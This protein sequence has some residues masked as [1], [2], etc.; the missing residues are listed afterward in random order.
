MMQMVQFQES[1]LFG[2]AN[3][4]PRP[5]TTA[6]T[7]TIAYCKTARTFGQRCINNQVIS[8]SVWPELQRTR[9]SAYGR[10]V[11]RRPSNMSP[12]K[13]VT[14]LASICKLKAG[15]LGR[16]SDRRLPAIMCRHGLYMW[17]TL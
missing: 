6:L 4:H 16:E 13:D 17:T 3:N 11:T 5:G 12:G 8:L 9:S 2:A 14:Q 15:R 10:C 1:A 7:G